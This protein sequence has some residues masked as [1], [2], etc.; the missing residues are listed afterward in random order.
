MGIENIKIVNSL[1]PKELTLAAV[2]VIISS[3]TFWF[4][5]ARG[6]PLIVSGEFKQYT[7][8]LL[9][10]GLLMV[11]AS[12]FALSAFLIK[13]AWIRNGSTIF[14]IAIPYLFVPAGMTAVAALAVSALFAFSA[15]YRIQQEISLSFGFNFSKTFW[16]GLPL[17]LTVASLTVTVYYFGTLNQENAVSSLFP[18]SALVLVLNNF[19]RQIQSLTGLPEFSA[20]STVD[21]LLVAQLKSQLKSQGLSIAQLSQTEI[22][23][24]VARERTEIGKQYN[25]TLK[26]NERIA[27][28]FYKTVT[29]KIQDL[30]GPYN[31]FLPFISALAFFFAFK[32]L[33]IPLYYL[34]LV[35]A[36]LLLK[37]MIK[38]G[39][40]HKEMVK[41][42]VERL[43][44]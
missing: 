33:T 28:V 20:N 6:I 19:S 30:L 9:P 15:T 39:L 34:A 11:T 42:E 36:Y 8:L 38:L 43:S 1:N 23:E 3:I 22:A 35:L 14:A 37:L 16:A 2:T 26:G 44:L 21:Q 40:V 5:H 13:T 10:L 4:W 25:V 31:K 12:L 7:A 24:T 29:E 17:Y 27:D 41:V 32:A 18:K